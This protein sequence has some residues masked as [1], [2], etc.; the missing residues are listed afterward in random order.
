L[1]VGGGYDAGTPVWYAIP[2]FLISVTSMSVMLAWLRMRSGSLWAAALFHATHNAT[3]QG[4][5]DRSTIDT[6]LTAWLTTEF[7]IGMVLATGIVASYFWRRR[8]VLPD[9]LHDEPSRTV[10]SA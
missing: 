1:I 5:F 7:G 8:G 2:C 4:V 6:G 3:I 9:R 10:A